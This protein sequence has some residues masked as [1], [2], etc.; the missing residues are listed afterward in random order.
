MTIACIFPGQGSQKVGML[1]AFASQPDVAALLAQ[2][3]ATLGE[4]LSRLIAQGPAED[5]SLTV[6]TQPAMLLAGYGCYL[7]WR[8]AGGAQAD[9]VA[10]H[11]LGEYTALV[12]AG[13][14]APADA[15]PLVR[16]RATAMQE[17]V[18]RKSTRLHSSHVKISYA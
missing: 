3:D 14:L 2:A 4:S 12:A 1:D 13:A 9:I 8:A 5:L 6:N 16:L 18:D 15:V 17:A 10:G 7:A 11:S